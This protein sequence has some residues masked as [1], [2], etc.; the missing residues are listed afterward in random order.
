MKQYAKRVTKPDKNLEN[1]LNQSLNARQKFLQYLPGWV[2][3]GWVLNPGI[4][5]IDPD[6]KKRKKC[7]FFT[8]S[9]ESETSK[10]MIKSA[11]QLRN[12][13]ALLGYHEKYL[14]LDIDDP[15]LL[16]IPDVFPKWIAKIKTGRGFH[17]RFHNGGDIKST[18]KLRGG[19][20]LHPS[21]HGVFMPGTYHAPTDSFY[22]L[23]EE[24]QSSEC[25]F[26]EDVK[27]LLK[28]INSSEQWKK[29]NRNN[30]LFSKVAQD[31]SRNQGRNV[32][33]IIDDA[34][35]AG[36]S[37]NEVSQTV[38]SATK[39]AIKSG[40]DPGPEA[41]PLRIVKNNISST[42]KINLKNVEFTYIKETT[43]IHDTKWLFKNWFEAGGISIIAG[44]PGMGKS[45]LAIK[46]AVLNYLGLPLY[47]AEN[48]FPIGP[49]GNDRK[50]LYI[51]GER[52]PNSA[53]SKLFACGGDFKCM[54]ILSK[55]KINDKEYTPDFTNPIHL[56]KLIS[57]IK[58]NSYGFIIIDPL[59]NLELKHQNKNEEVRK[60]LEAI[61]SQIEGSD[62]CILGL[63]HLKKDRKFADDLGSIRGASEW[64]NVA[65][66]VHKIKA[67]K[68]HDGFVLT[69]LKVNESDNGTFGGLRFQ[70]ESKDI[71][72][73]ALAP[74][75]EEK[76]KGG[77]EH[78]NYINKYK[79]QIDK[80]AENE[81]KDPHADLPTDK[82]KKVIK[83]LEAEGKELKLSLIKDLSKAEGVSRY[84]LDNK[85]N[86]E[87]LGYRDENVKMDNGGYYK[88]LKQ[89]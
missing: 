47:G 17:Y 23:L 18:L 53:L 10:I 58:A 31:L 50:S 9:G 51:C 80:L 34:R 16:Q 64:E 75:S 45:T 54:D 15:D 79:N 7:I 63:M 55:I 74:G 35:R 14:T 56:Q 60:K 65:S 84:F 86:L 68:N 46:L 22:T 27:P 38:K 30:T 12:C 49:E 25:L 42:P 87:D 57:I 36:L 33:D 76:Q 26:M 71:P 85:L 41:P 44:Q 29:G 82:I 37:K 77:I 39:T 19:E 81:F 8:D 88:I 43:K 28:K 3:E 89:L 40:I 67:L 48:G 20:L 21:S 13:N 62:T 5:K 70:I 4:I 59:V 6:D 83:R 72:E 66:C 11:D 69:K 78:L 1:F 52:K 32:P 24:Q 61:L 73:G 2:A